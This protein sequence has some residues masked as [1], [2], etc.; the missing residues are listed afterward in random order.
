MSQ[1]EPLNTI[2]NLQLP[3]DL[4]DGLL[5]RWAL[6]EDAENL[7]AFNVMIH[8]DTPGE[9]EEWLA[10]WTADL[11]NGRH[12]TTSASDFTIVV[13]Q[14]AG[15]KIV[16]TLNLISQTWTYD[17]IPF[18]VGRIE[19]VGTDPAYRR[20]GL[21]RRQ[22][23][24]IHQKS[25][26]RGELVQAIT[27]VPWYYRQFGYE[28]AINLEGGRLFIWARPGN[29]KPQDQENYCLRPAVQSDIPDLQELYEQNAAG[30]LI[31][32]QR[33]RE[34][35]AYE[36]SVAH[37]EMP[38]VRK[39]FMVEDNAGKVVAYAEFSVQENTLIVPEIS[40]R[41]G[42]SWRAITL[43]LVRELR[44]RA[45]ALNKERKKPITA[46]NFRLGES[47]P[48]YEALGSQLEK[49]PNPYNWYIRVPDLPRF[50][51]HITPVLERR[52]ANGV[53]AGHNGTLRL[54]FYCS[55]LTLT[56]QDGRL[57]ELGSYEP[58]DVEDADA[59][60]PDLTF[61]QLLFGHRS[62]DELDYARA[63][64]YANDAETAV[65]LRSLFPR[66]PSAINPLN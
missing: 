3:I 49:A 31:M 53:M 56:F 41:K 51:R 44:K 16:S 4:G 35:W 18:P 62:Y 19:L 46:I 65:L 26:A 40:V 42:H 57:T 12:P 8:T 25:A 17:G 27:G 14:Q 7:G 36:L 64:C 34:I 13:D 38:V 22:M 37:R 11:M 5:L 48:V 6:P 21:I 9:P 32:H 1:K 23:D 66:R 43:F 15:G 50:L 20:R 58:K 29:D 63:D 10:D 54:N 55:S 24:V 28:M 47:H 30:S 33:S 59:L 52:L 2:E 60:F 39:V 61:L 45:V